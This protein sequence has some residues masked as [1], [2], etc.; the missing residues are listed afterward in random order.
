MSRQ[1]FEDLSG[2]LMDAIEHARGERKLTT[3]KVRVREPKLISAKDL[4]KLRR[5]LAMSQGV[6]AQVLGVKRTSVAAWEQGQRT[7]R[8]STRRL[9]ELISNDPKIVG[10]FVET[11]PPA[12]KHAATV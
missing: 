12:A 9:L 4:A 6:L 5:R 10:D 7:P 3:W 1:V 2:A 8:G 11:K